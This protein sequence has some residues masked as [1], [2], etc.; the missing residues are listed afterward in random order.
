MPRIIILVVFAILTFE[1]EGALFYH[2]VARRPASS[3]ESVS[4]QKKQPYIHTT[5]FA[6][7]ND[8]MCR[9]K[10]GLMMRQYPRLSRTR[11]QSY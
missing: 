11:C 2:H 10:R 6:Y 5:I 3:E 1:C 7:L 9:L 8:F 4:L